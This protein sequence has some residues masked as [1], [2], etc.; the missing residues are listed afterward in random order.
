MINIQSSVGNQRDN[1]PNDVRSIRSALEAFGAIPLE[2]YEREPDGQPLGLITS[3]LDQ[4]IRR[5]Q[6][7]NNLRVD[8]FVAPRGET[9]TQIRQK[10]NQTERPR[11][12]GI[13][14]QEKPS[15]I[16]D[17]QGRKVH[18]DSI[19]DAF[20]RLKA[21]SSDQNKEGPQPPQETL[22]TPPLPDHKPNPPDKEEH[23]APPKPE[24]KPGPCAIESKHLK[25][26]TTNL[27]NA[28]S[29]LSK[30]ELEREGV[31]KHYCNCKMIYMRLM[32]I[33]RNNPLLQK[34]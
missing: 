16:I 30:A 17:I 11:G 33:M 29:R 3:R 12:T 22:D 32:L 6:K 31:K 1:N 2:D 20:Q 14:S 25:E 24:R 26:A 15:K 13:I 7:D 23:K 8:G 4:G 27:R 18:R 9:E 28:H 21:K 5:F 19:F 34:T 10:T